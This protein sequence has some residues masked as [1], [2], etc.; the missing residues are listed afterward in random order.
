MKNEVFEIGNIKVGLEADLFVIAGPCV[1]KMRRYAL[2]SP[3]DY[4]R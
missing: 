2:R 4:L 3:N 1:L